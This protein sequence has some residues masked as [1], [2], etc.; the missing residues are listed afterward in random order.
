MS[1]FSFFPWMG[2][3]SKL[4]RRIVSV[5]PDHTCYVE[6]FCGAANI[7]F[8]K[9]RSRSEII[10]DINGDLVTLFR[11]VRYHRRA[12]LQELRYVTHS[13]REFA[14]FRRQPGL[15][16][17]QRAA[18]FYMI[19]KAAFGGK[20]GTPDC[21]FGYGTTGRG[22]FNRTSLAALNQCHKRLDGVFVEHLDFADLVPR[23]DRPHTCF[24]CDPPY[25]DTAGYQ[26]DFGADRHA[27][28][29]AILRGIQGKF[30]LSIN[31]HPAIR[32]LYKGCTIRTLSVKYSVSRKKTPDATDRR[33]LLIA[34]YKFKL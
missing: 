29:A 18:R 32:K 21:H 10:N 15:T 3:K 16:D 25:L 7:L 12:F 22:R 17:I 8:A 33:E 2:G 4:A 6:V 9:P 19:L 14:D 28:L 20:G 24:Y 11:V 27:Q 13:R 23:Y 30:L 5:M 1:T 26:A 34:N 31:D